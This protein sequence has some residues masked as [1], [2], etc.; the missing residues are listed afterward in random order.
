MR[1]ICIDVLELVDVNPKGNEYIKSIGDLV[2]DEETGALYLRLEQGVLCPRINKYGEA[3][4]IA[5]DQLVEA[6]EKHREKRLE[7]QY[8]RRKTTYIL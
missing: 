6:F 4:T 7:L 3:E 2:A 5:H 8:D 1:L